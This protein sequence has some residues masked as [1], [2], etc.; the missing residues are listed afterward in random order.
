MLCVLQSESERRV[1]SRLDERD[2]YFTTKMLWS[3]GILV[4]AV[5]VHERAWQANE[6]H[7]CPLRRSSLLPSTTYLQP[8]VAKRFASVLQLRLGLKSNIF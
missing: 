4:R 8:M 1:I 2:S 3:D 7:H 5:L 6:C